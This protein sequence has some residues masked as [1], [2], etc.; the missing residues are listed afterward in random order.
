MATYLEIVNKVMRRMREQA[1]ASVAENSYS[2]LIGEF[3]NDAKRAVEDAWAWR[4]LIDTVTITTAAGTPSYNLSAFNSSSDG[5]PPK[6]NARPF[7]D[8]A[9]GLHLIRCTTDNKERFIEVVSQTYKFIEWQ[10]ASNDAIRDFPSALTFTANSAAAAGQ[11]NLRV[12]FT[13]IP[14]AAY[15][16]QIWLVNPQNDL[17]TDGQVMLVPSLPVVQLAYLYALYER[18][19]ELGEVL[20]LTSQKADLALSDAIA[21]DSS[22]TT[23][24]I[25]RPA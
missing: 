20:T 14:D 1:V 3:V 13:P 15:S 6:E 11:T 10:S 4:A 2:L 18:G 9:S 23:D 16:I 25:F 17:T 5:I 21:V 24:L 19:E 12:R 8:P 7:I 22:G